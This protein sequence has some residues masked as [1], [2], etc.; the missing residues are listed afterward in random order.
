MKSG[1]FGYKRII[2]IIVCVGLLLPSISFANQ[3]G[4][5]ELAALQ[6]LFA[7]MEA[8]QKAHHRK[9]ATTLLESKPSVFDQFS[10]KSI[11]GANEVHELQAKDL[12]TVCIQPETA[13]G[14]KGAEWLLIPVADHAEIIRRQ[15]TVKSFIE[16][17]KLFSDL[18]KSLQEVA[19][20]ESAVLKYWDKEDQLMQKFAQFYYSLLPRQATN[21]LNKSS[22]ALNIGA[23]MSMFY[24]THEFLVQ[25]CLA[26]II[27]TFLFN[28]MKFKIQDIFKSGIQGPKKVLNPGNEYL[29]KMSIVDDEATP[30]VLEKNEVLRAAANGEKSWIW[31]H[32]ICAQL[33]GSAGDRH[34]AT[35]DT[36]QHFTT[37]IAGDQ[38]GKIVGN[39]VGRGHGLVWA[40]AAAAAYLAA[41]GFTLKSSVDKVRTYW[42]DVFTL[43]AS[44]KEVATFIRALES[45]EKTIGSHPVLATAKAK[46]YLHQT[47]NKKN[48]SA[49]LKQLNDILD[50]PMFNKDSKLFL[51]GQLFAA[52]MLMQQVKGELVPA[53]QAVAEFDAYLSLAKLCKEHERA[54]NGFTFVEF[55]E[56]DT[57]IID[58][59]SVWTPFVG[60]QK[61]VNNPVKMGIDNKPIRM[62]ITGPNGGGKSIYFTA[63]GQAVLMAHSWGIV[64]GKRARMTFFNQ[65]RT[66][67][68]PQEDKLHGISKFMAQKRHIAGIQRLIKTSGVDNKM[69]VLLDEPYDG[70]T[71]HLMAERVYDLGMTVKQLPHVVVGIATHVKKPIE[72]ADDGS[73]VNYHVGIEE[74]TRGTFARTFKLEEGPA[75]WW[76]NDQ[77]RGGRY[78]DWLDVYM[79]RNALV[80]APLAS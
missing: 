25:I 1:L 70:T 80:K 58:I 32:W 69:L 3:P 13:F 59:D 74:P 46:Q 67:F 48:W 55:V 44:L 45:F 9:L 41:W 60:A 62:I 22:I 11:M 18:Q 17:E 77:E 23:G 76:F 2:N 56:N 50:S 35:K 63:L 6:Q 24:H 12:V 37:K 54:N 7:Q 73:F 29:G 21:D 43:R 10:K 39:T 30:L 14:Y 51:P 20:S 26:G 68:A 78:Q 36:W 52:H 61:A 28:P 5:K 16:D 66:S 42:A 40:L 31:Q 33:A 53:M 4:A 27:E 49:E 72:L 19:A 79:Q 34:D 64:P 8:E 71:E 57:P 65:I 15:T 75:H 47:M 38:A